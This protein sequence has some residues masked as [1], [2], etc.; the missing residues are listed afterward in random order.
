MLVRALRNVTPR[1][2]VLIPDAGNPGVW[3]FLWEMDEPGRYVKPVG[4]GNMGFALPASIASVAA[5]PPAPSSP[6][7][8]TVRWA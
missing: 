6:S 4:F 3:S 2:A 7:S 1:D 5:D 8:A